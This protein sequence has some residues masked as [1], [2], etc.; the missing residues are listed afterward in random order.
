MSNMKNIEAIASYLYSDW[1]GQGIIHQLLEL[2]ALG[3]VAWLAI[4]QSTS[5]YWVR[6]KV[7][8]FGFS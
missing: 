5:I 8:L 1:M 2:I 6:A 7:F 4:S 3:L